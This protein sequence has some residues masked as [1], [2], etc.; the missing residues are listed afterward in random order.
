MNYIFYRKMMGVEK[1]KINELK[2]LSVQSILLES[3][4]LSRNLCDF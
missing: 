4:K 2:H 3:G 1:F